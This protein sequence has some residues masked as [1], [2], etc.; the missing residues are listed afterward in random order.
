MAAQPNATTETGLVRGL[1]LAGAVALNVNLMVGVGPFITM[2]LVVEAMGGPQAMLGWVLGAL[3]AVCDGLVVAELGAAMPDAGGSYAYIRDIY[4]PQRLGKLLSFLYVW[5]L[6][7]SAPLSLASGAIGFSL[8][9]AYLWPRLL[10]ELV[11]VPAAFSGWHGSITIA[12]T[13]LVAM[14][15]C[16]AATVLAYRGIEM[17]GRTAGFLFWGVLGTILWTILSGFSHFQSRLAFDFP[18][19]AFQISAGFLH[20]LGAAMLITSYDYWGYYNVCFLGGEVRDPGRTIPRAVIL[21]IL[22]VAALYLMMTMAVLG[23]IPWRE[24]LTTAHSEARRYI[25]AAFM[26]R[27]YGVWAGRLVTALILWTAFA[28]VFSLLLGYSRVPY[29]AALDGNYF[30]IFGRLHPRGRFP[31]VSVLALGSVATAFC[32]LTLQ[33]AIAALVVIR[34][35]LQFLVQAVGVLVLRWK[36]PDLPRPFRMWAYP[37]PAV[38]AICGFVYILIARPNFWRELRVALLILATGLGVYLVRARRRRE[39]PFAP[40]AAEHGA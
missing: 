14:G 18:P 23:V 9:A 20:G 29:A 32:L 11:A 10:R 19:G 40:D 17:V 26:E 3:L 12:A 5:Q 34:L 1:G 35:L 21:S 33:Q 38:A 24:M 36:R 27:L 31:S 8:Y 28:S 30:R 7:F 2:P 39:W 4:G 37:L 25:I 16:M 13:T 15:V 22:L 6:S